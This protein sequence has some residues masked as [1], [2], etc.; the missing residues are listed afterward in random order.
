MGAQK[1]LGISTY[2]TRV[3]IV[4]FSRKERD[5]FGNFNI[6]ER[7]F[8]KEL[9]AE[10]KV[11]FNRVSFV[12]N[13]LAKRRAKPTIYE[14]SDALSATRVYGFYRD[15]DITINTPSLCDAVITIEGLI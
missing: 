12:Q 10:V 3:G 11:Q 6:V 7:G 9:E 2:G 4:D 13:E 1:S 15:F 5:D 8:A 14:A